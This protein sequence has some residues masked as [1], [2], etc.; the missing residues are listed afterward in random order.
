M[1]SNERETSGWAWVVDK[2]NQFSDFP[3]LIIISFGMKSLQDII[4]NLKLVYIGLQPITSYEY[5]LDSSAEI[6]KTVTVTTKEFV[7]WFESEL[8][9]VYSSDLTRMCIEMRNL[10]GSIKELKLVS[11][12][13]R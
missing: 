2:F 7:R 8:T 10:N 1:F 9:K 11:I 4:E 13:F 3:S 12:S 5:S 6:P